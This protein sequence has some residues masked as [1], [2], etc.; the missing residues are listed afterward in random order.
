MH[1]DGCRDTV[2]AQGLADHR[3][4]REVRHVVIV[5]HIE[6]DQISARCEH[7]VHFFAQTGEVRGKD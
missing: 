6:V 4:D 7:G 2:L 1:V 5:H 3:A